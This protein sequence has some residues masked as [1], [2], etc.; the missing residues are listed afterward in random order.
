MTKTSFR[1]FKE[2]P[3]PLLI[4]K[5]Q[6]TLTLPQDPCLQVVHGE[7]EHSFMTAGFGVYVQ[8]FSSTNTCFADCKRTHSTS[9]YCVPGFSPHDTEHF[10]QQM[11]KSMSEPFL[12]V[13]RPAGNDINNKISKPYWS[14]HV[15]S[16]VII[17]FNVPFLNIGNRVQPCH[18][19]LFFAHLL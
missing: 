16:P 7:T 18:T 3:N 19:I 14:P 2:K 5:R 9:R 15:Y 10:K 6:I 8:W 13:I 17:H 12:K 4:E 1:G 11:H